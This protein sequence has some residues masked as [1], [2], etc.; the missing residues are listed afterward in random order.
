[1]LTPGVYYTQHTHKT[2][3]LLHVEWHT[4]PKSWTLLCR[5]TLVH[6]RGSS[7]MHRG[8]PELCSANVRTDESKHIPSCFQ[9]FYHRSCLLEPFTRTQRYSMWG[10]YTNMSTKDSTKSYFWRKK[11]QSGNHNSP[12]SPD[13]QHQH[14]GSVKPRFLIEAAV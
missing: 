14:D 4:S 11:N 9:S 1:M 13:Q 6:L 3:T 12:V 5:H 8:I 7:E 2:H 10:N